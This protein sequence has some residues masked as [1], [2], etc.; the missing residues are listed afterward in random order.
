MPEPHKLIFLDQNLQTPRN[1]TSIQNLQVQH[2]LNYCQLSNYK[3]I[4]HRTEIYKLDKKKRI[5]INYRLIVRQN[6]HIA[7]IWSTD[8]TTVTTM[9]FNV[10]Q[11]LS[12]FAF[13]RA[14]RRNSVM[15]LSSIST[16]HNMCKVNFVGG[17]V[18]I[19]WFFIK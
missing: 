4:Q 18:I 3:I 2:V 14:L 12:F 5:P 10:Y 6:L 15:K 7:I 11:C 8:L 9:C 1:Q 19:I 13:M 17:M 16:Q